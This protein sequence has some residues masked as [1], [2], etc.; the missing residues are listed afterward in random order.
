ML[1]APWRD[2]KGAGPHEGPQV[3][4]GKGMRQ[5]S[6]SKARAAEKKRSDDREAA[7]REGMRKLLEARDCAMRAAVMK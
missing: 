7:D 4:K 6:W 1:P 5:D 3:Q 2:T